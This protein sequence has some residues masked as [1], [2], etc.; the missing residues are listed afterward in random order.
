M[1]TMDTMG[2][3]P[4]ITAF[5]ILMILAVDSMWGA[6]FRNGYYKALTDLRD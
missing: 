5:S 2:L 4:F 3:K 1:E 6:I